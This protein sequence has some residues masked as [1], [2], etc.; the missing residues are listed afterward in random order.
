VSRSQPP[1]PAHES[2]AFLLT[3][4]LVL[5][6]FVYSRALATF[7]AQDDITFL[8]RAAGLESGGWSFRPLSAGLVF[9]LEYLA[10][11]LDPR[12]YHVV[13]L[14]L[15]LLNVAGVY[16]LC[17][18]LGGSRGVAGTAAVLFGVSSIAFTPLHWATGVSELLAGS[19]LLG[20]TL[21]HLRSQ[22]GGAVRCWAAAALA[23]AAMFSK[24]TAVAWV[25]VVALI[26]W[27]TE[28]A[29]RAWP[30]V[31]PAAAVV[32]VFLLVVV[33]AGRGRLPGTSGAYAYTA[34]PLFLA[35]NLFTYMRWC[36]A[37]NEPIRDALAAADPEAWRVALPIGLALGIVLWHERRAV[38]HPVPV[39]L[40]W[41]LAFLLPVLPLTHHTY[42]YYLY[43]PWA[44]GAIA[45]AA[46]GHSLLSR[47]QGPWAWA[48]GMAVLG[49]YALVEAHDVDVRETATR[50]ALPVDRTLRDAE[51][52][53]HALPAL[54]RA[55][56][57]P[58]TRVV[59]VNPVPRPR[60]D[61]LTGAAT[62]PED[63]SRRQSYLPLE[64]AMR[65][66]E[67]LR[68]FVPGIVYG[69]FVNTI[70]PD[71]EEAECFY[72]EQRGWLVHWGHGQQALLHQA[73]VEMA[74]RSWTAAESTYRR[75]R[76]LG[77][78]LPSALEG[79]VTALVEMGR[80]PEARPIAQQLLRR[81]PAS[82]QAIRLRSTLAA[83]RF[84]PP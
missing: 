54:H 32:I 23:L 17:L 22:G 68:L 58:G 16:A 14:L 25:L 66:G 12:G 79:Q 8:S 73:A 72:F 57:A 21:L 53:G 39:G 2:H 11:G 15:H 50:D 81:W 31:L 46:L 48:V 49:G 29:G 82:P 56:L 70:P 10:F 34:S 13:N 69:G 19:L 44:G 26:G 1:P 52:L 45:L 3:S 80:A 9:R 42:L 43:I 51:L 60:F 37:L 75:V 59:F 35:Q 20:A 64:A 65:G 47:W 63:L 40:G 7:F 41:W 27:R 71:D 77:D 28:R 67:S 5:V 74:A 24:E 38:R 78:T 76:A 4:I 83:A 18:R 30:T 6:A 33:T 55:A 84:G 62:R 61:L 36:V